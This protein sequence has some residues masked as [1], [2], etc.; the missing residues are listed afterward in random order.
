M[1]I[2]ELKRDNSG[3]DVEWQAIEFDTGGTHG[4]TKDNYHVISGYRDLILQALEE[5]SR[6]LSKEPQANKLVQPTQ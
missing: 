3:A 5:T 2:I 6:E 1:A 4:E